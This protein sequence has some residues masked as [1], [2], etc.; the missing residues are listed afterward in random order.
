MLMIRASA[1][2]ARQN[3]RAFAAGATGFKNLFRRER[4]DSRVKQK[5]FASPRFRRKPASGG[6]LATIARYSGQQG[7]GTFRNDDFRE[8]CWRTS[9][10]EENDRQ[11]VWLGH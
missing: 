9:R 5:H 10:H 11:F 8:Q 6:M 4:F 7:I 2:P 3:E 1:K